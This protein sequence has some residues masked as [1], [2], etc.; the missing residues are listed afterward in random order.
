VDLD[1]RLIERWRP[2]D[3]RPEIVTDRLVWMI[4]EGDSFTLD[5]IQFFTEVNGD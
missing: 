4:G 2:G 3:T 5:L 1:A